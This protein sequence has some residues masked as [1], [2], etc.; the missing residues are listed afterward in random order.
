MDH[1]TLIFHAILMILWTV[2]LF[3]NIFLKRYIQ[4]FRFYLYII[5][6]SIAILI[7]LTGSLAITRFQILLSHSKSGDEHKTDEDSNNPTYNQLLPHN[8]IG[9]AIIVT[10]SIFQPLTGFFTR[11]FLNHYDN[12]HNRQCFQSWYVIVDCC[13]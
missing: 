5:F 1:I 8:W 4:S 12:K 7:L 11:F 9:I 3:N 2:L 13:C 10:V 6:Q